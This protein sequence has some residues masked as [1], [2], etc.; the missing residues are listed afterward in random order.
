LLLIID[1]RQLQA[2][3]R[4]NMLA[5]QLLFLI[6]VAHARDSSVAIFGAGPGGLTAAMELAERGFDVSL[7]EAMPWYGGKARSVSVEGTGRNGRQDLPGEHGFRIFFGFYEHIIDTLQRIP[8]NSTQTVFDQLEPVQL[9]GMYQKDMQPVAIPAQ[10]P[11]DVKEFK[12]FLK[13]LMDFLDGQVN[14]SATEDAFFFERMILLAGSCEER[15]DHQYDNF[16]YWDFMH[17]SSKSQEFVDFYVE[18]LTKVIQGLPAREASLR[19]SGR[20]MIPV[21]LH[22]LLSFFRVS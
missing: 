5:V 12:D 3:H 16:S 11:A 21:L 13:F 1:S 2:S 6:V 15:W 18:G 14:I 8:F 19:A 7:Y 20:T 22:I 9:V 10:V 17:A 4:P